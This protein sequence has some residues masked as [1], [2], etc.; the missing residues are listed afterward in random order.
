M[1]TK[2]VKLSIVVFVALM[3]FI[4]TQIFVSESRN[5]QSFTPLFTDAEI[6]ML[7]NYNS[8]L[9]QPLGSTTETP[10]VIRFFSYFDIPDSIKHS[11][12]FTF[13]LLE[14]NEI[15]E[16]HAYGFNPQTKTSFLRSKPLQ[17]GYTI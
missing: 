9:Y 14:F 15:R 17:P 2:N 10:E 7:N 13:Y 11:Y 8:S 1:L 4:I 12:E 16:L 3:V 6:E 5:T